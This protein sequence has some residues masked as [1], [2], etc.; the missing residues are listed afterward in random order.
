[1]QNSGGPVKRNSGDD[2]VSILR[3]KL[4]AFA[5]HLGAGITVMLGF[6]LYCWLVIYTPPIM[7]LEGGDRISFIAVGVDVILGP[8]LTFILY[9]KGKR[10]LTTD[11]TVVVL[12]QISAFAYGAWTLCS[13]RPLY[14]AFVAEHFEVMPA[15]EI[16]T[17]RLTDKNLA[18][19]PF[20][21]PRKVYV[22]KATGPAGA[23]IML[24]ATFGGKDIQ[25]YPEYYRPYEDHLDDIRARAQS[26]NQL[27][28]TWPE[29]VAPIER[30][31][32]DIGRTENEVMIVPIVGNARQAAVLLDPSNGAILAFAD[33][34]IW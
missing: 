14:L 6:L 9:R 20:H 17:A 15:R 21:G 7:E 24:D 31:L 30:R 28:E 34:V 19:R 26:L 1:M 18:P 33:A 11:I 27:R 23:E 29:A 32:Q 5:I 4:L 22:I 8:V 10:G 25:Y 16:D 12:L 3:Q 2:T 13:Q